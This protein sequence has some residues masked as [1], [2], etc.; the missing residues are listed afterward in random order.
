MSL[1]N[2]VLAVMIALMLGHSCALGQL[3]QLTLT[4]PNTSD[5]SPQLTLA[6]LQTDQHHMVLLKNGRI[7]QG[8]VTRDGEDYLVAVNPKSYVR[9][10]GEQVAFSCRDLQAAYRTKRTLMDRSQAHDHLNMAEWCLQYNLRQEAAD[11][12]LS[13]ASLEPNHQRLPM[14]E[15]RWRM[16]ERSATRSPKAPASPAVA[17]D[18]EQRERELQSLPDSMI[19]QFTTTIQPILLNN[20]GTSGCHGK[21]SNTEFHLRRPSWGPAISRGLTQRNLQNTLAYVKRQTPAE[22]Q[23][24]HAA[25]QPHA[26]LDQAIFQDPDSVQRK[27]LIAWID[28]LAELAPTLPQTMVATDSPQKPAQKPLIKQVAQEEPAESAA[29]GSIARKTP[30]T[31]QTEQLA[32]DTGDAKERLASEESA[33]PPSPLPPLPAEEKTPGQFAPKDAFDAAIFNRRHGALATTN[34]NR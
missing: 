30:A 24:L 4:K 7:L 22:S 33:K 1:L 6:P 32:S 9:L 12:L 14:L 17:S 31:S 19:R 10:R 28:Q 8:T 25:I 3:P 16:L 26:D 29:A 15:R 18:K 5:T 13:A 23:L 34:N 11:H 21:N 2:R 20:C 27:V